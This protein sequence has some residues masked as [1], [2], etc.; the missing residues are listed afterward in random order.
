MDSVSLEILYRRFAAVADEMTSNLKRASR[1][2]YVKEAGDFGTALI[3]RDG[4]VFA[5]P[6]STSVSA[7]ERHCGPSI[8]MAAP[9]E[10][11]DVILTNDPYRSEGLAT[12][13]PDLHLIKPYFHQGR[14]VAYGWC[15]IHFMDLGGRV[16]SSISPSSNEI[17][18]EGLIIPPMKIVKRNA[19]NHDL[20]AIFSTNCRTPFQNVA[21]IKAMLGALETGRQRVADI[22]VSHGI[23]TFLEAQAAVQDYAAA[24]TRQVLRRIPDGIYEFWDFMDDD[25]KSRVPLRFR[26]K[27]TARDG[28]VEI[29]VSG[30]DPQVD[31]AYNI[32]TISWRHPWLVMR[33]IR[34]ILTHD[35]TI[36]LNNGIYRH[37]TAV[38]PPGTA[39][40]AEFPDAVGIRQASASRLNDALNG[41]LLKA[42]PDLMSA[43]TSGVIVPVVL[44]EPAAAGG[45]RNVTV[46]EPLFGGMGAYKGHDGVDCRD[47]SPANLSNHPIET[48][49]SDIGVVVREY[50][51]RPD[52]G[53]AGR[54]RG[55]CGQVLSFEVLK[56]GGVV[57]GRGMERMRFPAWGYGGSKPAARLRA[58]LNRGRP[59]E[60]EL[61]KIDELHVMAG[62]VV[63]FMSP[64]SSGYGEPLTPQ[65]R[66]RAP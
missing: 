21:D 53:G 14:I 31:S 62:D 8:R 17:F 48:I 10:E 40:N 3:D 58:I 64:G 19:M 52:S 41:T 32:P 4:H 39:A 49:E 23:A 63:T 25:H 27:L 1:S 5:F 59:D 11:G 36:P 20:V 18:Q 2:V 55:G 60:Q 26:V 45:N 15:F 35:Q 51:V 44:V 61:A 6:D 7:I 43:L 16:P 13:L 28:E 56:D 37:I 38:N 57:L 54:W 50:D 65:P 34:F 33:L 30:T 47:N 22:I 24:K 66:S 46:I 9:L 29:D 42:A 12:H